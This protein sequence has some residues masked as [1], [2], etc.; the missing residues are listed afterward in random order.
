MNYKKFSFAAILSISILMI[1]GV[2]NAA[3]ATKGSNLLCDMGPTGYAAPI[4]KKVVKKH[5]PKKITCKP[6]PVRTGAACPTPCQPLCEPCVQPCV[7]VNPCPAPCQPCNPCPTGLA[8]PI[9]QPVAPCQTPCPAPCEPCA[10]PCVPV[11]PCPAPCN[12]CN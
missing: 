10:Q 7:P 12:P 2:G 1:N 9:V 5:V 4:H 8:A 6:M 11:N 3:Q